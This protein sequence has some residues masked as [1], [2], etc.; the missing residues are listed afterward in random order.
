[1]CP[2]FNGREDTAVWSWRVQIRFCLWR[3]MKSEIY[4]EKVNARDELM[5]NFS[6]NMWSQ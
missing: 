2:I 1:M 3:W 6:R 5:A 4:K